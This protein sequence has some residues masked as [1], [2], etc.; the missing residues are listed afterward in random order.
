M[1]NF[2]YRQLLPG[3]LRRKFKRFGFT[4]ATAAYRW[5]RP[6]R[7]KKCLN[8]FT[9]RWN[10]HGVPV[11]GYAN[12]FFGQFI[13]LMADETATGVSGCSTDSSVRLVKEIE[14]LFKVNLF[15]RQSLAFIVKDN[16]QLLPMAQLQYASIIILSAPAA[17]ISITWCKQKRSWKTI[18]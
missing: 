14:S 13:V 4:S 15:D 17:F 3:I 6:C 18:G 12:L 10:S 9:A 5:Q 8:S 2:E 11:K 7:Q 16:I 1:N